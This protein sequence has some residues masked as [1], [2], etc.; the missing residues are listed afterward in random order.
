MRF[1]AYGLNLDSSWKRVE[2]RAIETAPSRLHGLSRT[3]A[4]A[5]RQSNGSLPPPAWH[6]P[7]PSSPCD[8]GLATG[9]KLASLAAC[10]AS[11]TNPSSWPWR[12]SA[13]SRQRRW[14]TFQWHTRAGQSRQTLLSRRRVIRTRACIT[15]ARPTRPRAALSKR[16]IQ[17][18]RIRLAARADCANALAPMLRQFSRRPTRFL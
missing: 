5:Q 14:S 15:P 11:H 3:N 13:I 8:N 17:A 7:L 4:R 1:V 16:I 18:T 6:S 9:S 12:C 2:M 10:P